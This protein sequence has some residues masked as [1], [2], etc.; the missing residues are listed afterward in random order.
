VAKTF[1]I[2][3]AFKQLNEMVGQL[4][5]GDLS[6]SEALKLYKDGI[7]LVEK[8]NVEL[9]KVEKQIIILDEN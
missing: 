4:E 8:C 7:K 3:E 2:E 6:L 1:D 5:S 9:D